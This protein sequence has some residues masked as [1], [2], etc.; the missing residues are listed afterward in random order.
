V[1]SSLALLAG[2][3]PA[4]VRDEAAFDQLLESVRA[5]LGLLFRNQ[6]GHVNKALKIW[7]ELT[8]TLNDSYYNT[9]PDVYNDMRSQLDDM[10]YAGFLHELAPARLAHYPR[11]LEA[12]R[13]RLDS[14]EKD[15]QRD[16]ERMREINPFW[17]QYLQLLEQ[18]RDY[19]DNVDAYRWLMEEFRVSLFAQQLGTGAKVS[20]QRLRKAWQKIG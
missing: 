7:S 20:V 4:R 13:I 19:D 1:E 8:K 16:A 18:G 6:S 9:R 14:V 12:M 5:D 11:Y 15:P 17:Q 2:N 3:R 10:M